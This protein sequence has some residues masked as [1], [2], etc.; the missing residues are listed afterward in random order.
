[1]CEQEKNIFRIVAGSTENIIFE[2][3]L[4]VFPLSIFLKLFV[5]MFINV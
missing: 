4:A 3:S 2:F 1:V 5:D